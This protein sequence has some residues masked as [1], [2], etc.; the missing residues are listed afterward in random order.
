M[1]VA[2]TDDGDNTI[3]GSLERCGGRI[4][5]RGT[6][7]STHDYDGAEFLDFGGLAERADHVE[8]AVPGFQQIQQVSRL[9]RRLHDEINC[10]ALRIG[11]FDGEGNAL[12]VLVET[13]NDELSRFLFAGDAWGFDDETFYGWCDEFRVN[14]LE[15]RAPAGAHC[16]CGESMANGL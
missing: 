15:H 4:G 11:A 2:C 9:A 13:Q 14:D 6:D 12:A 5:H 7:S 16:D 10:A 1:F 3:T 8:D